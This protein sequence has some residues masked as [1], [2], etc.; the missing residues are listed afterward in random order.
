MVSA[1]TKLSTSPSATVC[2]ESYRR[3]KAR[4]RLMLPLGCWTSSAVSAA[5]VP[6]RAPLLAP[7]VRRW[8]ERLGEGRQPRRKRRPRLS[9]LR[10]L[11][12]C[13]RLWRLSRLFRLRDL[14]R[15]RP[16]DAGGVTFLATP[17]TISGAS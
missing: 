1:A 17:S 7:A 10:Q 16:L 9:L 6:V 12:L 3:D 15:E 4:A 11:R 14:D 8:E 5:A 13:A 2:G